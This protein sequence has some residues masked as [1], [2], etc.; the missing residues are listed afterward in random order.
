MRFVHTAFVAET[1]LAFGE[2]ISYKTTNTRAV[3][4]IRKDDVHQGRVFY[5]YQFNLS[6]G[7]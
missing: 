6:V 1:L 5:L 2:G 4:L 3:P 7:R